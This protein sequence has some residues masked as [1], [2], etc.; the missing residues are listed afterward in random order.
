M[1]GWTAYQL[2][3]QIKHYIMTDWNSKIAELVDGKAKPV[4]S[5]GQLEKIAIQIAC[6]QKSEKPEIQAP[7]V[8]VFAADHGIAATNKVNPY[9]QAI[10]A[11]MV[12]N[13]IQGGAAIHTICKKNHIQLEIVDAG[14]AATFPDSLPIHHEKMGMGTNNYEETLAMG[15]DEAHEAMNRGR[16]ITKKIINRGCNTLALGEMGIGNSSSA[17]LIMSAITGMSIRQCTGRGT[18]S[19]DEQLELKMQTLEAVAR[20][21]QS[22]F[23]QPNPMDVL[24]AVGGFEIAMMTGA[25]LEA[26]EQGITIVVD[27]FIA[28][29]ALLLAH[30]I[31]PSILSHCIF[32]HTSG[33]QGHEKML[34]Y[35]QVEPI[36][37]LGMRLGEG[38]GAAVAIPLIQSALGIFEMA[39][40]KDL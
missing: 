9:P 20:K 16:N 33:E 23:D 40:L 10:T 11:L 21:H 2:V 5:L 12:Y 27:G 37:N 36:L 13:F 31:Q 6:I 24:A 1:A 3:I 28:T 25:Y 39:N 35:L 8:V 38:T 19:S 32:A 17:A 18:G 7:H 26:Y 15:L 22:V 14:V 34:Q 30:T 4:G 29:S